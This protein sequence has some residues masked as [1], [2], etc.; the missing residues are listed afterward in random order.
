MTIK[1]EDNESNMQNGNWGT[2]GTNK[3]WDDVQ[4]NRNQQIQKT[5]E[6]RRAK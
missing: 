1:P 3:Q 5:R 4:K 2:P 6:Q